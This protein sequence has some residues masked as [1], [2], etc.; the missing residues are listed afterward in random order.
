MNSFVFIGHLILC[1]LLVGHS[2]NLRSQWNSYSLYSLIVMLIIWNSRIQVSTN[3]S[4]V[5]K[6]WNV[7]PTKLNDFPVIYYVIKDVFYMTD[8]IVSGW[9]LIKFGI[10]LIQTVYTTF[11]W[12]YSYPQKIN[13]IS[14]VFAHGNDCELTVFTVMLLDRVSNLQ[15]QPP[16]CHLLWPYLKIFIVFYLLPW[17]RDSASKQLIT[18][19]LNYTE[20]LMLWKMWMFIF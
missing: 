18:S 19:L 8:I 16:H 2:T 9:C 5:V 14:V 10:V 15:E 11:I 1:I 12:S 13:D 3:M 6:P 17:W 7:V 20:Y 4:N